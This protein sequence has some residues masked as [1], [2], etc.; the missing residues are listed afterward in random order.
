MRDALPPSR[1]GYPRYGFTCQACGALVVTTI[2]RVYH[3]PATG[4][5]RRFCSPACRQAAYRRR[6]AGVAEN[7]PRQRT[8]GRNRRLNKDP[9]GR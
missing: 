6:H 2:E 1:N 9:Q 3:N 7:S 5:P 4:S 8:G